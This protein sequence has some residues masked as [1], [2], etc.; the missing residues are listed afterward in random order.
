[1][2]TD[3]NVASKHLGQFYVVYVEGFFLEKMQ[4]L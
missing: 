3:I 1:M 2:V 4:H